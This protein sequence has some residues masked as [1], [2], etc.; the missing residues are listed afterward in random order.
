MV[1]PVDPASVHGIDP[2][3]GWAFC[4]MQGDQRLLPTAFDKL[5]LPWHDRWKVFSVVFGPMSKE[6]NI[7]MADSYTDKPSEPQSSP[8]QGHV[9]CFGQW[10][11]SK[12]DTSKGLRSSALGLAVLECCLMEAS[13]M[14]K[15]ARAGLQE[16]RGPWG[17]PPPPRM[18][19][20]PAPAELPAKSSHR[21]TS[22]IVH[23]AELPCRAQSTLR[24]RG[25]NALPLF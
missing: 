15:D 12:Y 4:S 2:N 7:T 19:N 9:T 1:P 17:D 6:G 21:V 8:S 11:V 23:G 5:S 18:R 14:L 16:I 22:A 25:K 24:T 20:S 13:A 10:N 3:F